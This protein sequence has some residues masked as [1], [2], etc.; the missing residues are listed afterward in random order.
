[1]RATVHQDQKVFY[2]N[3]NANKIMDVLRIGWN[4]KQILKWVSFYNFFVQSMDEVEKVHAAHTIIAR[5][6]PRYAFMMVMTRASIRTFANIFKEK[7]TEPF[8]VTRLRRRIRNLQ[9]KNPNK[10]NG[11]SM[12]SKACMN[13]VVQKRGEVS[14]T[15]CNKRRS[16]MFKKQQERWAAMS[17]LMKDEYNKDANKERDRQWA[18][19]TNRKRELQD[20][21]DNMEASRVKQQKAMGATMN[22]GCGSL[23]TRDREALK[24]LWE[25]ETKYTYNLV[26]N[27]QHKACLVVG[28]LSN[29]REE[30]LKKSANLALLEYNPPQHA[31]NFVKDIARH[32][33]AFVDC[34]LIVED[35]ITDK[36]YFL[37]TF[38]YGSPAR[39]QFQKMALAGGAKQ[40]YPPSANTF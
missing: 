9:K 32:R 35:E 37:I 11:T 21:L 14:Y 8:K 2:H 1:M 17:D 30:K 7:R 33:F 6:H 29:E 22:V 20:S 24:H 27:K 36:S 39:V 40:N 18:S 10:I 34:A 15:E 16:V 26:Q 4:V 38:S 25:D 12:W 19:L 23:A 28:G 3:E 13:K 5:W 31:S